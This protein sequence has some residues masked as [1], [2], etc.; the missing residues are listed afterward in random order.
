VYQPGDT[1]VRLTPAPRDL[2]VAMRDGARL[3]E[4][5]WRWTV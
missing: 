5:A 1:T 4:R 2:L 3:T